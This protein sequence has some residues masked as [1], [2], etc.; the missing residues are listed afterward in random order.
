MG[1]RMDQTFATLMRL[2]E[3]GSNM[4]KSGLM[5]ANQ[6]SELS[7]PRVRRKDGRVNAEIIT[8]RKTYI[9]RSLHSPLELLN[10]KLDDIP[11]SCQHSKLPT[12]LFAALKIAAFRD[13]G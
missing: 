1:L 5:T 6:I 13:L 12:T 11:R 3:A 9:L 7:A 4:Q 10:F 2:N 8:I